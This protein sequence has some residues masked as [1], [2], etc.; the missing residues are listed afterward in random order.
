MF[1]IFVAG[2]SGSIRKNVIRTL[3][4]QKLVCSSPTMLVKPGMQFVHHSLQRRKTFH[5]FKVHQHFL[6][7]PMAAAFGL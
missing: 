2:Q 5:S 6:W 1:P 7:E 4:A 3:L